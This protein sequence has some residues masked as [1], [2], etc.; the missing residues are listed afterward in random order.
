MFWKIFG[1]K[2]QAPLLARLSLLSGYTEDYTGTTWH[3][4]LVNL[5]TQRVFFLASFQI[6][7]P[8]Y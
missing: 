5:D 6:T 1:G 8:V 4:K 3:N 7:D 2:V